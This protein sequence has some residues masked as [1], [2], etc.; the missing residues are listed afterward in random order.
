MIKHDLKS[1]SERGML[2]VTVPPMSCTPGAHTL[3][4]WEAILPCL[5][6]HVQQKGREISQRKARLVFCSSFSFGGL[7]QWVL[8]VLSSVPHLLCLAAVLDNDSGDSHLA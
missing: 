6:L 5:T 2:E 4:N 7:G 1:C 3:L 8:S